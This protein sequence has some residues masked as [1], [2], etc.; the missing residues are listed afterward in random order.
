MS[1]GK[2]EIN[3]VFAYSRTC[4]I[5]C[6]VPCLS[7]N[8]FINATSLSSL[9]RGQRRVGMATTAGQLMGPPSVCARQPQTNTQIVHS[10]AAHRRHS[11]HNA[12]DTLTVEYTLKL[13]VSDRGVY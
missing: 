3:L 9:D 7:L 1:A 5:V 11:R 13:A 10:R 2:D 4:M 12:G 6:P 8:L